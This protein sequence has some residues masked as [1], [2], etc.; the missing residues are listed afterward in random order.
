[1]NPP[2]IFP[3]EGVDLEEYLEGK[4]GPGI[5]RARQHLDK[6]G[7]DVGI[8]FVHEGKRVS[9]T[10]DSH[11]IIEYARE[12]SPVDKNLQNEIVQVLFRR[13]FEENQFL[14]LEVLADAAAEVGL[15]RDAA[16]EFLVSGA[17]RNEVGDEVYK[18][19]RSFGIRGVPFFIVR[20]QGSEKKV[21]FSGAQ[22]EETWREAVEECLKPA[23][24]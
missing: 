24:S 13:Y 4:Y 21:A 3:S 6:A 16:M 23:S 2:G 1:L 20:K 7:L 22:D 9:D 18:Y 15:D 12:H 10:I 11:R 14:G 8:R 19:A 5:K 17:A